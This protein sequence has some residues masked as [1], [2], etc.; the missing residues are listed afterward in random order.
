MLG[1]PLPFLKVP[2]I[3]YTICLNIFRPLWTLLILIL[4]KLIMASLGLRNN[5]P[6]NIRFSPMNVWRGQIGSNRGFCVFDQMENG[7]RAA[8]VLLHNYVKRGYDTVREI[9]SRWAPASENDTEAYIRIIV[10]HFN[11]YADTDYRS[12]RADSKLPP[13]GSEELLHHL[14]ELAWIMSLY[15]TGLYS[16]VARK[17]QCDWPACVND[18]WKSFWNS[19]IEYFSVCTRDR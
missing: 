7:Y 2:R 12:V 17:D 15:E 3:R 14:F 8:F 13:V 4:T 6:L 16:L 18:L 5:N 10:E 11:G 9:V 19:S 1:L